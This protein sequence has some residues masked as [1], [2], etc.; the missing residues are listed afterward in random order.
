MQ[1]GA[2]TRTSTVGR[3]LAAPVP[4]GR[5]PDVTAAGAAGAA[6]P[7][8][9]FRRVV[10]VAVA[11]AAV[12]Y[13]WALTDLWNGT[14]DLLRTNGPD[15]LGQVYDV[16]ARAMLHGRLSLPAGSIGP[17]AFV[18]DGRTYTYFGVFPSLIRIPVLLVTHA[19]DG[20]LTTLSLLLAWLV[21]ALAGAGLLWRV[22][23]V[24]RGPAELGWAEACSYGAVLTTVL[25]GSVLVYLASQPDVYSEDM[26]W[27]VALGCAS[28]FALLGVAERPS[29]GRIVALGVAVTCTNLNRAT[30][31]YA[32][33]IGCVLLAAWLASGRAGPERRRWGWAVAAVA[34]V[35]LAA[36]C[37][38]D[39]AK[40]DLL[41]GFPAGDQ[42]LYKAFGLAQVNH[43]HYFS[44]RFLPATLAAYLF[45]GNLRLSTLFPYVTLPA[46]PTHLVDHTRLFARQHVAAAT[47]TTPLLV[48]LA[49]SGLVV[50]FWPRRSGRLRA[51]R[52]PLLA[53]VA[54][55]GTV[56]VFGWVAERFTGDFLPFLV[57][58]S[59][60]GSTALWRLLAGQ[61]P[62]WRRLAVGVTVVAALWSVVA[63]VGVAAVPDPNWTQS[64][65][66]RYVAVQHAL[67][68]VTGHP[69]A[70]DVVAGTHFPGTAPV[71][72]L[73]VLDRCRAL[74][75]SDG[76]GSPFPYPDHVWLPVERAP[77]VHLCESVAPS[78]TVAPLTARLLVP[79]AGARL[80]GV[81]PLDGVGASGDTVTSVTFLLAGGR[82]GAPRT[83]GTG[84]MTLDGWVTP[85]DTR[86]VPDGTYRL[87]AVARDSGRRT[88]RSAT[89]TVTVANTVA[90]PGAAPG[91]GPVPGA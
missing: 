3:A 81:V 56:L 8:R 19:F 21:T 77:D 55:A 85:W 80:S 60:V 23:T 5:E 86:A 39:L 11:V 72:E 43:G 38:V 57:V 47:A 24:V 36:G 30:T 52:V 44:L 90:S 58:G 62:R 29:R 42:V 9:R 50:A 65:V 75:V 89:V 45:P 25:A 91:A 82:L 84:R 28:L 73:F 14:V 71:G 49:V 87:W 35:A 13:L 2:T 41:V 74:Y 34:A 69:L 51:V 78:A 16:Q 61:R 10:A 54:S 4:D 12:P 33:V 15:G 63:S 68:D 66:H 17:E 7:A 6:D 70:H 22:R 59:A 37:A 18:H 31:G 76:A 40:F 83:V 53:G 27:S 88:A 48:A 1:G 67:S 32:A 20:R 64:Q 79:S 26:A 46:L